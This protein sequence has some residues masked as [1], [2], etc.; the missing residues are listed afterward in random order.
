MPSITEDYGSLAAPTLHDNQ[1]NLQV[2]TPGY[3]H[4]VQDEEECIELCVRDNRRASA[5][6]SGFLGNL[7]SLVPANHNSMALG[8]QQAVNSAVDGVLQFY[9][10]MCTMLFST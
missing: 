1:P 8:Q 5:Y 2:P 10:L 4:E 9:D 7:L 6:E 3:E